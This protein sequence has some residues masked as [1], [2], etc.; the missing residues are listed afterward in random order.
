M[1]TYTDILMIQDSNGLF[2]FE[3][4]NHQ[5]VLDD[6]FD[7]LI[8]NSLFTDRRASDLEV[9]DSKGRRG[10]PGDLNEATGRK[11]GSLLWLLEQS[12]LTQNTLNRAKDY[13]EKALQWMI[14]DEYCSSININTSIVPGSGMQLD[15]TITSKI[16]NIKDNKITIW[17]NTGN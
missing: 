2:D 7:T 13:A 14:E 11:I 15:I 9:S 16:G 3:I 5:V 8:Y 6:G 4:E 17:I 12:R 1:A 10:W